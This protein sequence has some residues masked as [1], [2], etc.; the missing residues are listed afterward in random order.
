MALVN[1][2]N[3]ARVSLTHTLQQLGMERVELLKKLAAAPVQAPSSDIASDFQVIESHLHA[4]VAKV[5]TQREEE[6]RRDCSQAL[7]PLGRFNSAAGCAP[8]CWPERARVRWRRSPGLRRRV[9]SFECQR[10]L[11]SAL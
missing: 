8:S 10:S 2:D 1:T 11:D 9:D 6:G 7:V 4:V 5:Q 3:G